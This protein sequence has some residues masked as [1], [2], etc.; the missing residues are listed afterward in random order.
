VNNW[1][2]VVIIYHAAGLYS[3]VAHLAKGT[4]RV[5]EGQHLRRGEVLGF[6]GSSGRSPTPH[7]H[8]QLQS[9]ALLG[10][11]TLPCRFSDLV[12]QRDVEALTLASAPLEGEVVRNLEPQEDLAAFFAI[13]PGATLAFRKGRETEHLEHEVDLLGNLVLRSREHGTTLAFARSSEG[14][15]TFDPLGPSR[16]ALHL[17]RAALPRVPFDAAAI[18]WNDYLPALWSRWSLLGPLRDF[19]APFAPQAGLE[20]RYHAHRSGDELVVLGESMKQRRGRPLVRTR[21]T[22]TRARGLVAV[23]VRA[24]RKHTSCERRDAIDEA[25]AR[26]RGASTSLPIPSGRIVMIMKRRKCVAA[27]LLIA[28]GCG[29][30]NSRTIDKEPAAAVNVALP[31]APPSPPILTGGDTVAAAAFQ[32]SYADEIAGDFEAALSD[33]AGLTATGFV[34]YVVELRRGWLLSK[35]GRNAE[36]VAAYGSASS[37]EPA[38]VEPRLGTLAPLGA[39]RRWPEVESAAREALKRDPG[40]YTASIRLAYALH[41]QARYAEA[42]AAYRALLTLYPAD[43][44]VRGGLGWSLLKGNKIA[45]AQAA[46]AAVLAIAPKNGLALDGAA[47]ARR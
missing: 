42:E 46:F 32:K 24:G 25:F 26:A 7:L 3:L 16:S 33:L 22:L 20:M 12:V 1:G 14:L 44:D 31:S 47:A 19:I 8:F 17:V 45:E 34:Q 29:V 39:L 43:V 6:C 38:A 11:P 4:V 40:N 36:S 5:H 23:E 18:E 13:E 21:A 41:S 35:L 28:A 37:L 15:T 9:T 10:A 30:G 27:G 2:N